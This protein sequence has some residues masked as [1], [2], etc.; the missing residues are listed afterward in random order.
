MDEVTATLIGECQDHFVECK[1]KIGQLPYYFP[2]SFLLVHSAR[3]LVSKRHPV[4]QAS[5]IFGLGKVL[6]ATEVV[7]S[8]D[9]KWRQEA[10]L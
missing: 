6:F 2:P 8:N 9:P 1:A 3:G 7:E 4:C 5:V 10:T